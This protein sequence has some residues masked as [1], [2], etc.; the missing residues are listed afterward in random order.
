MYL[1]QIALIHSREFSPFPFSPL[2]MITMWRCGVE[3]L[4]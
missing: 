2:F 1:N 4:I 3:R